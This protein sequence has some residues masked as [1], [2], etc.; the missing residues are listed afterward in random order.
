[1]KGFENLSD[2]NSRRQAGALAAAGLL[3]MAGVAEL[4]KPANA[5]PRRET[6]AVAAEKIKNPIISRIDGRMERMVRELKALKKAHKSAVRISPGAVN[7]KLITD[8]TV[9]LEIKNL[10]GRNSYSVLD[11]ITPQGQD[12]PE[13][14]VFVPNSPTL[15][16]EI[17]ATPKPPN[18]QEIYRFQ[19]PDE[20]VL[21]SYSPYGELVDKIPITDSAATNKTEAEVI[22]SV[23]DDLTSLMRGF[24]E[25]KAASYDPAA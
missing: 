2:G 12:L 16:P 4:A 11:V 14:C 24:I 15:D 25:T 13:Y 21:D 19:H 17:T 18:M 9:I 23:Y 6:T 8:Y 5:A 1:M 3:T 10:E 7:G 22:N 20:Y